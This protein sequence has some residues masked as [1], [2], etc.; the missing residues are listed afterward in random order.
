MASNVPIGQENVNSGLKW[1]WVALDLS[2]LTASSKIH[3][4]RQG[5]VGFTTYAAVH[6]AQRHNVGSCVPFAP[7]ATQR[8]E[9]EEDTMPNMRHDFDALLTKINPPTERVTLVS[10]RVGEVRDWLQAHEFATKSPH[11]QLSGSYSRRTAIE[12]I[13]DVDVLLFVP[14]DQLER[15][16]NAVLLELH[17]VLKDYPA[18]V[19]NTEGQ[20]RSVRLE[21][22]ADD[23]YLDI[24]PAAAEN[25]LDR[26][27]KVPDRPQEKWILSDPL[28][29]ARRLT[30]VNQANGEKVVP[31]IKLVKA[32]R[33]EQMERRRPK[34]YVLEVMLLYAVESG[35]LVLCDRSVA[36]NVHD[37]FVYITDKYADL[38]DDGAAAPRIPDPQVPQHYITKGWERS[39]FET[40]MR[41]AREAR[42]AAERALAAQDEAAA[43]E[44]WKRVF[45]SRWP[46]EDEVKRAIREE[47][48][49]HQPGTARIASSG[50]VIGGPAVIATRPTRFHGV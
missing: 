35:E 49:A 32:W 25:G 28:G 37:A 23:L 45:G 39:H 1:P 40:F 19:I 48:A 50:R 9:A 12:M 2:S 36:D 3:E 30:K 26:P 20:R 6:E 44:E 33:D 38:M 14:E 13:P 24:V 43:S 15:T 18:A 11:T 42:R 46:T 47:A 34:S 5:S 4:P 29:Y 41:R 21:L 16:P 22:P 7:A 31:L 17:A 8:P 10:A 27:L